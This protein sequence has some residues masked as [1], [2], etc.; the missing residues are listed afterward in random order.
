MARLLSLVNL[1]CAAFIDTLMKPVGLSAL[2][3]AVPVFQELQVNQSAQLVFTG[4]PS[5]AFKRAGQQRRTGDRMGAAT[6]SGMLRGRDGVEYFWLGQSRNA[7]NFEIW[8][9]G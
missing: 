3:T 9:I 7:R 1:T 8:H 4:L 2:S 5:H 6:N